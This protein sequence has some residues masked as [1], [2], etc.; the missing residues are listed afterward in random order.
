MYECYIPNAMQLA[1]L[2]AGGIVALLLRSWVI[3]LWAR[4]RD[5]LL[6]WRQ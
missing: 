6:M 2:V 4:S 3:S 5:I 1:T